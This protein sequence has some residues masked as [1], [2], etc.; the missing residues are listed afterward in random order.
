MREEKSVYKTLFSEQEPKK[1]E[2]ALLD[3]L[4]TRHKL[5]SKDKSIAISLSVDY[6]KVKKKTLSFANLLKESASNQFK[7][8][9]KAEKM[10]KEIGIDS[11]EVSQYKQMAEQ[12]MQEG[13]EILKQVK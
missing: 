1:V 12:A 7:E 4:K 11:A 6:F 9:E 10:L 5:L 2:L 13:T 3:S 8:I